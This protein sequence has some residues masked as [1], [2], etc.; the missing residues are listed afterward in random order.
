MESIDLVVTPP[1]LPFFICHLRSEGRFGLSSDPGAALFSY[2][3]TLSHPCQMETPRSERGEFGLL[4]AP[5]FFLFEG[6]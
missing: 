6:V 5:V 1:A 4:D 3:G 2:P